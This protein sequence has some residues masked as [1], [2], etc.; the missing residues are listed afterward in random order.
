MTS[1]EIKLRKLEMKHEKQMAELAMFQS[2]GTTIITNPIVEFLGG[3]ILVDTLQDH[4]L[5]GPNWGKCWDGPQGELMKIA[6]TCAVAL[7]QAAPI[8]PD[9][10]ALASKFIPAL[11]TPLL[12]KT[13]PM[14]G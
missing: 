10:S 3:F 8:L 9:V 4:H 11:P 1:E 6:I 5:F 2:I 7:Q 13:L 14:I 12:G